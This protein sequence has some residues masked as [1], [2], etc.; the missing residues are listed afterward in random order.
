[1]F[2]NPIYDDTV[3]VVLLW[4]GTVIDV[5]YHDWDGYIH[6]IRQLR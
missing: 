1:M 4:K 3:R 5:G 6:V 2:V